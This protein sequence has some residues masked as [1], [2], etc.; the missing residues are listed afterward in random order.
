[1]SLDPQP[2][3]VRRDPVPVRVPAQTPREVPGASD[4]APEPPAPDLDF[5]DGP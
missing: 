2:V 1:M 3:D 5:E 4:G